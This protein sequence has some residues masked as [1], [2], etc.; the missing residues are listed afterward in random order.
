MIVHRSSLDSL[1]NKIRQFGTLFSV[2]DRDG[3]PLAPCIDVDQRVLV[4]IPRLRHVAAAKFDV[5]RVGVLEIAKLH[6]VYPRSKNAF[7]NP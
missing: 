4:K 1:V 5:Q 6:G 2:L 3:D 7:L